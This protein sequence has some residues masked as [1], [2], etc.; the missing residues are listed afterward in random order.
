M[1]QFQDLKAQAAIIRDEQNSYQNTSLRVGRMFIDI[2][3]QLEKVLPDENVKPE[4]LT[5]EATETIYK[6]KF[7]TLT[8]D[9]SVKSRE[10]DLPI[11]TDTK[12]GVMS[13]ALMKGIKDQ[14]SQLSLKVDSNKT[15]TDNR[16]A[17]LNEELGGQNGLIIY[18]DSR[19][20]IPL[21][22]IQNALC[23]LYIDAKQGI[24]I[25]SDNIGAISITQDEGV[26]YILGL[27]SCDSEGNYVMPVVGYSFKFTTEFLN[28][29]KDFDVLY[30][31]NRQ[32]AFIV[33]IKALKDICDN[34]LGQ[35][36]YIVL[37]KT[38]ITDSYTLLGQFVKEGKYSIVDIINS[39]TTALEAILKEDIEETEAILKE[40]IKSKMSV[41]V[42]KKLSTN[43]LDVSKIEWGKFYYKS[44]SPGTVEDNMYASY[45][46]DDIKD[47]LYTTPIGTAQQGL[48]SYAVYG[49]NGK[50]IR[51]VDGNIYNYQEGD[52]HV[53]ISWV[54]GDDKYFS[55]R[56]PEARINKGTEELP[57]EPYTDYAPL[58]ELENRVYNLKTE[59]DSFIKNLDSVKLDKQVGVNLLDPNKVEWGKFYFN[60]GSPGTSDNYASYRVD[61]IKNGLYATKVGKATQSLASFAV[62]GEDNKLIRV[63]D[64]NVYEYEEGDSYVVTSYYTSNNRN[65]FIINTIQ[66]NKGIEEL[67]Y[68]PYTDYAPLGELAKRIDN[69]ENS[70][71]A[72]IFDYELYDKPTIYCVKNDLS[73]GKGLNV[74][75]FLYPEHFLYNT[76]TFKD[77]DY[78]IGFTSSK[79]IKLLVEN[80]ED[81]GTTIVKSSICCG[82][83]VIDIQYSKITT[84]A[85]TGID[86]T[87]RVACLGDSVGDGYG[88]SVQRTDSNLPI[89]FWAWTAWFFLK[90]GSNYI[91]IGMPK[92]LYGSYIAGDESISVNGQTYKIYA[93]IQGGWKIE[94]I[95]YPAQG[96]DP[97]TPEVE[98]DN[99]KNPF[100]NPNTN[101]FSMQYYLDMYRTMDDYGNRLYFDNQKTTIGTAGENN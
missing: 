40:D 101:K 24:I 9:G 94:E 63:V 30:S 48:A 96:D 45:R 1:G 39:K 88:G 81:A 11:A 12:A 79:N 80:P 33:N 5:V 43:L 4:T 99:Y 25:N 13:P 34:Y 29:D 67:P 84:L 26:G 17:K 60:Y 85:S 37:N 10:L 38:I 21:R 69:L 20:I 58:D 15:D 87:P 55:D 28:S 46:V 32:G 59:F 7:S 83:K 19:N 71:S 2:L 22:L 86:K 76:Q 54:T 92:Y 8:S 90:D 65:F 53:F 36:M 89:R 93:N 66:I 77:E 100:Y 50:F 75:Q 42:D 62:F 97:N 41:K 56:N 82:T 72:G 74:Q 68:Q 49:E 78:D 14:I 98:G 47:G 73:D 23:G 70:G 31:Y 52:H 3:E 57:Y 91:G 51:A 18:Y 35:R 27:Y 44:G 64:G 16:I 61:D 6:L 95:S